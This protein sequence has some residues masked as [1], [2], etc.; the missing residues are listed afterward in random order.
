MGRN[1]FR[2]GILVVVLSVSSFAFGA[3]VPTPSADINGDGFV[4]SLDGTAVHTSALSAN[5]CTA[6]KGSAT[7][8][9]TPGENGLQALF[10]VPPS[11]CAVALGQQRPP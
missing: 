2:F 10:I 5:R 11:S 1:M 7:Y 9:T 6:S 8:P 4:D 3:E